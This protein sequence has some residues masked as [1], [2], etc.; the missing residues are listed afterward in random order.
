MRVQAHHFLNWNHFAILLLLASFHRA[1]ENL[2]STFPNSGVAL[3]G[4]FL[5]RDLQTLLTQSLFH[6]TRSEGMIFSVLHIDKQTR[7]QQELGKVSVTLM[8]RQ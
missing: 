6:D 3:I 4:R 2:I 8:L 1:T 7:S 5:G